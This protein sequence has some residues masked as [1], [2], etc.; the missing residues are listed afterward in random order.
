MTAHLA[1]FGDLQAVPASAVVHADHNIGLL[2]LSIL[3]A[4]ASSYA[5]FAM[6]HINRQT[7]AFIHKSASLL[8]FSLIMG[9]GIWA[10]H[11]IGMLSMQLPLDISYDP[12]LTAL[13]VLPSI[14]G[15]SLALWLMQAAPLPPQ[16][17]LLSGS[18]FGLSVA[19]MHFCGLLAMQVPAHMFLSWP[20]VLASLVM[21][22]GFAIAAFYAQQKIFTRAPSTASPFSAWLPAVL[23][24]AAIASMHYVSLHSMQWVHDGSSAT[25][26]L[27]ESFLLRMDSN[28]RLS[29]WLAAMSLALFL[30]LGLANAL[31]RY[32][33]LWMAVAARDARL[34]AM[35]DTAPDGVVT[36]NE[37][38]LIQDFNPQAQQVFGYQAAEVMGRNISCLMP[39]PLAEQHDSHLQGHLG[40]PDKAI[41]V[42]GREVL[43]KHKDGRLIPLQLAI[44][45]AVTPSGTFFV[46]YL[47]D[48]S[49]RKRTD[50]QLRIAASVF[51]HVREGVAI[52]DANHNISDANPAFL[53]MMETTREH[54]VGQSLES[55]YDDAEQSADMSKLW[56]TVATQH[57]WQGENTLTRSNGSSWRQRLSI[58][59][60]LNELK[61]PH[62]FIAV[63]SDISARA[64][65]ETALPS[66]DQY[67][68]A[69][70]LATY[71]L[72]MERLSISLQAA[73][74]SA[75]HVGIMLVRI[76]PSRA[77][78]PRMVMG[79]ADL[80]AAMRL[81]A[82]L[83][84]HH[85]RA[86]DTIALY[87]DRQLAVLLPGVK[88]PAAL[89]A[90]FER[91]TQAL[92]KASSDYD[93]Y[94]IGYL[95]VGTASTQQA[96]FTVSELLELAQHNTVMLTAPTAAK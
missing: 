67:D 59:P 28:T 54:C 64:E 63:I 81:S 79:P 48:I 75:T 89:T 30:I 72:L 17:V 16:R 93:K 77:T 74:K 18:I 41:S 27:R 26:H 40:K 65:T 96:G 21:G 69:T 19:A 56:Q 9:I 87:A 29:L 73:R 5:A 15:A 35:I 66:A 13:S 70:G 57:Y 6:A 62:H 78:A 58:S 80:S 20:W 43:G 91:L 53:H 88:E 39:S 82:Q 33:D 7:A 2:V 85:I 37:H 3:V 61:R 45:K 46:G 95:E 4:F 25:E 23:M 12:T 34:R 51:E 49:E 22:M 71:K 38:G 92:D 60:V 24:T 8:C 44:G 10:M 36:I 42:N 55:L 94:N 1:L 31:L 14:L 32:R 83:L 76:A 68:S 90:L 50:A 11:F 86:T 84:Q 52:V 47:Q